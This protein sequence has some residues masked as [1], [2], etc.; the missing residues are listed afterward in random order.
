MGI[1]SFLSSQ[2][3]KQSDLAGD[4][5]ESAPVSGYS[6]S[7]LRVENSESAATIRKAKQARPKKDDAAG[8]T[9]SLENRDA[10]AFAQQAK[11]LENLLDPKVWRGAVAAPGDAMVAVTGRMHWKL[12]DDETDTLAKTGAA[13][14]RCFMV[15]DP[16]WLA[17]SLFGFSL[18]S[19]YG[20]RFMKD[21][22]DR[23][24]ALKNA[25]LKNTQDAAV[26]KN[27]A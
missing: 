15:T 7:T 14:A 18:L 19:I 13:T 26:L 25:P 4:D 8:G 22:K 3:D 23:N 21:V 17:L 6:S 20:S 5:I 9:F 12:Y 11:I 24:D 16:K 2:D 27:A 10:E 1:F